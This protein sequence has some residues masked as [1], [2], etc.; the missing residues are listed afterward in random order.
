MPGSN[1][2]CRRRVTVDSR[3]SSSSSCFS[4]SWA[5]ARRRRLPIRCR[6]GRTVSRTRPILPRRHPSRRRRRPSLMTAASSKTPPS[7]FK[8]RRHKTGMTVDGGANACGMCDRGWVCR[9][10]KAT[11]A[12]RSGRPLC[13]PEEPY[14]ACA[15]DGILDGSSSDNVRY[16][17]GER[18]RIATS[19]QCLG[20]GENHLL[21]SPNLIPLRGGG[22]RE[23]RSS[24]L[25]FSCSWSQVPPARPSSTWTSRANVEVIGREPRAARTL[26]RAEDETG[27]DAGGS[28]VTGRH[29]RSTASTASDELHDGR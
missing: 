21:S 8:T 16:V 17:D 12:L 20:H 10:R 18:R 15:S 22:E 29:G 2:S 28:T 1:A 24:I 13:E 7:P 25:S 6:A 3:D 19:F 14:G 11:L 9:Q 23:A 27:V 4:C 26:Y 5:P